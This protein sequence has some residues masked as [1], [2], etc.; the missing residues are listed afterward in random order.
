[1]RAHAGTWLTASP[2]YDSGEG[3]RLLPVGSKVIP[4]K[5]ETRGC[6]MEVTVPAEE[7][8]TSRG[9]VDAHDVVGWKEGRQYLHMDNAGWWLTPWL[10]RGVEMGIWVREN[11]CTPESV[12]EELWLLGSSSGKHPTNF[13][14]EFKAQKEVRT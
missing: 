4:L 8:E 2:R 14:A 7:G 11:R 1:M 6:Q 5:Q 13:L 9:W 10:V 12:G 3:S